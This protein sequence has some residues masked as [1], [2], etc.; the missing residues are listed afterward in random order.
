M[1]MRCETDRKCRVLV[2]GPSCRDIRLGSGRVVTDD[3]CLCPSSPS[4]SLPPCPWTST[5]LFL[6]IQRQLEL[7]RH[8]NSRSSAC[9]ASRA[10]QRDWAGN[11]APLSPPP[12]PTHHS[13]SSTR[14]SPSSQG[15]RGGGRKTGQARTGTT[16]CT[17]A[18]PNPTPTLPKS[19]SGTGPSTASSASPKAR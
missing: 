2:P 3:L 8:R 10:R 1:H 13:T 16:Q 9:T 18:G 14:P 12:S 11:S 19:S 5:S 15:M 17:R 4:S 7:W 6:L